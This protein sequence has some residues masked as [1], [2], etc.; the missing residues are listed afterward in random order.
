MVKR[1][2][3]RLVK[4]FT[5]GAVKT[6]RTV[7]HVPHPAARPTLRDVARECGLSVAAVSYALRGLHVPPAT[8]ERV[9]EV[10]D[11]LGYQANPMARALASG[12]T[13][14]VGVVCGSL[15][16][17]WQQ[18][19]VAELV[20]AFPTVERTALIVDAGADA[21]AQLDL[22][23]RLVGQRVD[24]LVVLPIDPAAPAW[25]DIAARTALVS[26]GDGLP[27]AATSAEVVFDNVAGVTDGL[28][29]LHDAGHRRVAVIS[30]TEWDTPDRPAEEVVTRVAPTLGLDCTLVRSPSTLDAAADVIAGVLSSPDPPTALFCLGDFLA[31]GAYAACTR[32][33]LGVPDDVSVL[34]YD[35]TPVSG[36][37]TPALTT[38]RWPLDDLVDAVLK[39]VVRAVDDGA[40]SR[41]VV[42]AP[43]AVERDSIGPPPPRT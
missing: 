39:G 18:S 25:S 41:R 34:G 36:V 24:A 4:R 17:G 27:G 10:A 15:R 28:T 38:Y 6:S 11:R 35:D 12:R 20:G 26:V 42:L 14:T 3:Y 33:G 2:T 7:G 8:Q 9:R 1:F 23:E 16:D 32:L 30:A 40:R 21:A 22:A 19:I 31:W 13:E 5:E 29:R 43:R 37:L